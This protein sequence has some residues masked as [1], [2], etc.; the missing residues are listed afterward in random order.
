METAEGER[1]SVTTVY[2]NLPLLVAAGIVRR[3]PGEAGGRAGARYEHVW[4]RRHHDHLV[5][6][7]CGSVVEF[8]YPAIEVLQEAVAAEHGF[9]LLRHSLEL[10]GLCESCRSKTE[11]SA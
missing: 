7:S 2:R 8:H 10:K 11:G 9:R 3:A 5:C 6:V 1:V 4:G